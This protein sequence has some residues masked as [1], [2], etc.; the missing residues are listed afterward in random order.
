MTVASEIVFEEESAGNLGEALVDSDKA[1]QE[2]A[3]I[4]VVGLTSTTSLAGLFQAGFFGLA[5]LPLFPLESSAAEEPSA[6][7]RGNGGGEE[8][9]TLEDTEQ[10]E[11]GVCSGAEAPSEDNDEEDDGGD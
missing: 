5:A 6:V 1:G 11:K 10:S 2:T 9:A 8:R 7:G 4:T 3:P